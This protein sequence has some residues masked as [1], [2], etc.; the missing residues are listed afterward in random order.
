MVNSFECDVDYHY[1]VLLSVF[2]DAGVQSAYSTAELLH[3]LSSYLHWLPVHY[4]IQF[5]TATLMLNV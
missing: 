3:V 2:C 5:K 1:Y 4:R